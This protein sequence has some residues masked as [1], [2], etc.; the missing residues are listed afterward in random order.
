MNAVYDP[1][2]SHVRH[3]LGGQKWE[4]RFLPAAVVD[5]LP[6]ARAGRVRADHRLPGRL[7]V[8]LQWLHDQQPL[9]REACVLYRRRGAPD[10]AGENHGVRLTVST[11]PTIARST[12]LSL[13]WSAMRAE[14]PET[15]SAVSCEPAPT[16]SPAIM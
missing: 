15:T 7:Q 1:D 11:L 13:Q 12:G 8:G 2:D 6:S 4:A 16:V 5:Q 3:H 14:L 9:P 10:R